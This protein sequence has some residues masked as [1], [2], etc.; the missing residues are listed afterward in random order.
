MSVRAPGV[1]RSAARGTHLVVAGLAT[2]AVLLQ[3]ALVLAGSAVLDESAAPPLGLALVRFL[4][5]FTIQ[6]NLLVAVTSWWLAGDPAQDG[7]WFRPVR[8]AALVGITVTGL[9]HY[10]L[11]RPLLDLEGLDALADTLLH[12]VVPLVAVLG[13]VVAGPRPRTTWRTAGEALAWPL[14]W[15]ASTLVVGVVSGWYPYPFLDHRE[16]GTAAVVVAC[17]GITVLF[18]LLFAG[19]VALDRRLRPVPADGR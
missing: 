7:R 10:V 13:W 15:T 12:V 4:C 6:S 16:G 9:V 17:A 11:L 2:A 8:L 5:Y 1:G 3:L 18:L 14:L 19:A